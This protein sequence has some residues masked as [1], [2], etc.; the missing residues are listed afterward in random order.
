[1]VEQLPTAPKIVGGSFTLQ[2]VTARNA[3]RDGGLQAVDLGEPLW[4]ASIDT[5]PL[6]P[7]QA[8][9]YDALFARLRGG[10]R[11]LYIY[12]AKRPRPIAYRGS[13]IGSGSRIGVSARKIG[14]STRKIGLGY[15]AWG[16]P[17][18]AAISRTAATVQL[19]NCVA[20]A[21]FSE[22]DYVAWD[23]G[24]ARRLHLV[25]AA[26]TA[27]ASGV[28]TLTVEP[29]PPTAATAVL[30]MTAPAIVE[31]AAAEMMVVQDQRSWSVREPMRASFSA[32]QV[33]RKYAA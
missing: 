6:S 17:W 15:Y 3:T 25:V 31:K 26:A 19:S 12:D 4:V 24:P 11:T 30:G 22:G 5:T 29:P 2:R 1:L 13:A 32:V 18:V 21:V 20:G 27:N 8:G 9:Q 23:D 7:T 33:I 28:V 16:E 14:L 10:A